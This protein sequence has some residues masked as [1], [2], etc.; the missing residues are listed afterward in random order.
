M[1]ADGSA[2][3]GWAPGE[4][5]AVSAT[6][7]SRRGKSRWDETPAGPGMGMGLGGATPMPGQ[8]PMVGMTPLATPM[9][10]MDMPTPSPSS[11]AKQ[12]LTAEQHQVN[13][14]P[15]SWR[16][17]LDNWF[18]T[19]WDLSRAGCL[20]GLLSELLHHG[21]SIPSQG[22]TQA[23]LKALWTCFSW[24][25]TDPNWTQCWCRPSG[26]RGRLRSATGP[27]PMRSWTPCCPLRAT[28]SWSRPQGELPASLCAAL[29]HSCAIPR[30]H[31]TPSHLFH[32][33]GLNHTAG[34]QFVGMM[35]SDVQM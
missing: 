1:Q 30:Q 29:P 21:L 18:K 25:G 10:G 24:P 7:G 16:L 26:W 13:P 27:C 32:L 34:V 9:G 8:T 31:T 12:P 5:P 4:T 11:L 23:G 20:A 33:A 35:V 28:R 15:Q 22:L 19:L 2:T 17:H 6:P 14:C 3:P